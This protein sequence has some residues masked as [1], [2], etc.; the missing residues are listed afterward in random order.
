[1][2]RKPAP[3]RTPH[4][5]LL[6][7]KHL[8]VYVFHMPEAALFLL[9][10]DERRH[11]ILSKSL[12][13]V[14][15]NE[16]RPIPCPFSA[17]DIGCTEI[18]IEGRACLILTMPPPSDITEAYFVGIVF[19]HSR[20][21]LEDH[22]TP[23]MSETSAIIPSALYFTLEMSYSFAEEKVSTLFCG[24]TEDDCHQVYETG[25]K[26]ELNAFIEAVSCQVKE[27]G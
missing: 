17:T 14:G 1:M 6:V 13:S 21:E 9:T 22:S 24:R 8:P 16:L 27:R 11:K 10:P 23:P 3:I 4:H 5:Y 20:K 26:P 25:I 15:I 12:E 2:K 19:S 7:H 18:E